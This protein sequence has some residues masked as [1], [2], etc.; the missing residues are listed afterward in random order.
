MFD[1]IIIPS[2]TT[3]FERKLR[4]LRG[5]GPWTL[6]RNKMLMLIMMHPVILFRLMN[7]QQRCLPPN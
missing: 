4:R 6:S 3:K 2:K 5:T 7:P 1:T